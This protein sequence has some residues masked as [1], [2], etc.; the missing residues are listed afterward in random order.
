MRR[1]PGATTRWCSLSSVPWSCALLL[2]LWCRGERMLLPHPVLLRGDMDA[3]D[4]EDED[5]DDRDG[6]TEDEEEEH[7][8]EEVEGAEDEEEDDDDEEQL[9]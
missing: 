1:S 8:E 5:E 6:D 9:E 4:E 3:D 2:P 7:D